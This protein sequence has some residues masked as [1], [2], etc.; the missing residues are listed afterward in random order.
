MATLNTE[1][2]IPDPDDFYAEL[3][4]AHEG[5]TDQQSTQFNAHLILLLANHIGDRQA[6]REALAAAA[7]AR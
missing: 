2:N 5:L 7:P 1:P 6:L 3:I 4:R